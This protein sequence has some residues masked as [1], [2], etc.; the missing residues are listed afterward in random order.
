VTDVPLGRLPVLETSEGLVVGADA[1]A[2]Y[3]LKGKLSFAGKNDFESAQVA[4]WVDFVNTEVALPVSVVILPILGQIHHNQA[5]AEKASADLKKVLD[6]LN[7]HFVS[8]T[9]LVGE[10]VGYADVAVATAL[11]HV[12][13]KFADAAFRKPYTHA[14]R[15]FLTVVNQ[16]EFKAVAGEF[17]LC[18]KKES[19]KEPVAPVKAEKKEAPKK[20]AAAKKPKDD[21]EEEEESY[22]DEAP[23]SK[24]PL[25]SLPPSKLN[26]EEWKRT[27]SNTD[28][29]SVAIPWFWEHYDPEGY[30]LWI[31][32]YKYNNENTA[33]FK[34]ANLLGG[35]IQ[36]LDKLRKYGFAS[37]VIFGEEPKLEVSVVFLT[38]GKTCPPELTECDD[39]E[40]YEWRQLHP[41]NQA[42]KELVN[43]FWAW[44]GNFGGK[45][46]NQ[47]KSFR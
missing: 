2:R 39:Y 27:Y 3:V 13:Q 46:L 20:E 18:E 19:P 14:N 41:E 38:R 45:K 31:G 9:F 17:T 43:D 22:E 5:A 44:D 42:D 11:Y 21:D 25:D 12:Y 40:H 24:N 33:V 28:T 15:W 6:I 35:F 34:T 32:D 36:R 30:A 37:M 4:S 8:R 10:R 1:A 16:P 23:K 7:K 26:L 47:A 29:R